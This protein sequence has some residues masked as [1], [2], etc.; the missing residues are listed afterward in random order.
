MCPAMNVSL[1][2]RFDVAL[3]P[4]HSHTRDVPVIVHKTPLMAGKI[5]FQHMIV[6]LV[7]KL[8]KASEGVYVVV[9]AIGH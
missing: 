2:L 9:A 8:V 3:M 7:G 1:N 4:T 5:Q 6:Y